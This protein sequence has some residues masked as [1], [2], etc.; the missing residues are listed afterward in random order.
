MRIDMF[1]VDISDIIIIFI[2]SLE[3]DDIKM[4]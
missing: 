2:I 3:V 4:Y 1:I